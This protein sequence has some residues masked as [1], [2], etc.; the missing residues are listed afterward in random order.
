MAISTKSRYAIRA[1]VYLAD[2]SENKGEKLVS[3]R[4]IGKNEGISARYLENIFFKLKKTGFLKGVKGDK[5]GFKLAKDPKK[6]SLLE[7]MLALDKNIFPVG[8]AIK[9]ET[10]PRG[11]KCHMHDVWTDYVKITEKFFGSKS[12]FDVMKNCP[13]L[14]TKKKKN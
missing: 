6:I 11:S 2:I 8:C 13:K 1:L 10:C 4:E 3:I 7:V 5:G 14:K 12:L 9:P